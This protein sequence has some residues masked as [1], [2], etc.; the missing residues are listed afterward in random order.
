M[1]SLID[2][3]V[4]HKKFGEG[5]IVQENPEKVKVQFSGIKEPKAFLFP[6]SFEKFLTL[7]N[8]CLQYQCFGMAISKRK[9]EEKKYAER[10]EELKAQSEE[11]RREKL[12][13]AKSKRTG[14]RRT[15]TKTKK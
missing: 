10:C 13:L 8:I 7:D 2:Q 3:K 9:M 11:K 6:V 1:Q 5:V 14:V 12:S 4:I 15:A